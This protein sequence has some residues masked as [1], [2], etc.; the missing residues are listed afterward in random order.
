M[1]MTQSGTV[2]FAGRLPRSQREQATDRASSIVGHQAFR[3]AI[4]LSMRRL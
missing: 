4:E 3:D 1:E 2:A